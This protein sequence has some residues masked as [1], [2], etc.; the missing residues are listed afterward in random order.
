MEQ[1]K[2]S[3]WPP[4]AKNIPSSGLKGSID[5]LDQ[6]LTNRKR[7][8]EF[9]LAIFYVFGWWGRGPTCAESVQGLG[10]GFAKWVPFV[11]IDYYCD[12]K[13]LHLTL[14]QVMKSLKFNPHAVIFLN[15][16]NIDL[17]SSSVIVRL[18]LYSNVSVSTKTSKRSEFYTPKNSCQVLP[19]SSIIIKKPKHHH[20]PCHRLQYIPYL[21]QQIACIVLVGENFLQ[22]AIISF[23]GSPLTMPQNFNPEPL[24]SAEP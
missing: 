16:N 17:E 13:Q 2:T 19:H 23:T 7:L 9:S 5:G 3:R 24:C 8:D 20:S 22:A 12:V 11:M 4:P 18:D 10:E 6:I 21:T 14:Y 15:N 1:A